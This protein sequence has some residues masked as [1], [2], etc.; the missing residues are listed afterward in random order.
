MPASDIRDQ[1]Q[2]ALASS[3]TILRELGGGGMSYVFVAEERALGRMV[4]IKVLATDRAEGVSAERFSRLAG[5]V[6]SF[7]ALMFAVVF[8]WR[9]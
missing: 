2:S 1:V 5:D 7:D 9:V 8:H 4:V 6:I 3:Y